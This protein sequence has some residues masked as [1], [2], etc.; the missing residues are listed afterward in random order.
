VVSPSIAQLLI[1]LIHQWGLGLNLA[2]GLAFVMMMMVMI[3]M[4][5][6]LFTLLNLSSSSIKSV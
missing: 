4:K 1:C 2:R 6:K 5:K 3:M